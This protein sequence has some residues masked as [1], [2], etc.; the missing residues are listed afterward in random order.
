LSAAEI[1]TLASGG[2]PSAAGLVA[3]YP[4]NDASG[5]TAVDTSGNGYTLTLYNAPLWS[6]NIPTQNPSPPTPAFLEAQ[7]I[8]SLDGSMAGES[9]IHTFGDPAGRAVIQ[10]GTQINLQTGGTVRFQIGTTGVNYAILTGIA[11]AAAPNSSLYFGSAHLDANSQP[12]LCR[13]DAT[14]VVTVIG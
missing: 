3:H 8:Q 12:K 7:V 1:S 11:D 5:S 9:G 10:A 14:G 2:E 4:F 6:L 13:K